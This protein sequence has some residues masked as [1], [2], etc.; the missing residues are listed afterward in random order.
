MFFKYTVILN[1]LFFQPLTL[2][3]RN[4]LWCCH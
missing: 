3:I 1:F 4:L 2:M